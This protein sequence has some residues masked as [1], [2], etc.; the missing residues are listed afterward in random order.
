MGFLKRVENSSRFEDGRITSWI[1]DISILLESY[2]Y[3]GEK[4]IIIKKKFTIECKLIWK[5]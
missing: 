1:E 3:M 5:F 2:L 4:K